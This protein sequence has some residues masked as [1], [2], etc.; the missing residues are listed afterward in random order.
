MFIPTRRMFLLAWA[1]LAVIV[2]GGGSGTAVNAAWGLLGALAAG[3]L[4]DGWRAASAFRLSLQRRTHIQVAVV[5]G[6][7][8]RLFQCDTGPR[9]TGRV[10]QSEGR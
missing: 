10:A 8:E 7:Q 4:F 3:W 2:L 9:C 1:P 6:V 5:D